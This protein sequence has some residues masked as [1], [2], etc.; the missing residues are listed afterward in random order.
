MSGLVRSAERSAIVERCRRIVSRSLRL[1][2]IAGRD[3]EAGTIFHDHL[4]ADSLDMVSITMQVEEEFGFEV[5][6]DD[7]ARCVTFLDL[8]RL[9][10][11]R[12]SEQPARSAEGWMAI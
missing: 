4:Q 11:R 9:V 5:S 10:E 12:L 1:D 6:D 3:I 2:Q 8:C 7:A